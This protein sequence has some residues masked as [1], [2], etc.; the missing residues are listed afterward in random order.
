MLQIS[1]GLEQVDN[2]LGLVFAFDQNMPRVHL[3]LAAHRFYRI[4]VGLVHGFIGNCGLHLLL[5]L[6][7][8]QQ[9]VAQEGQA[10]L[11]FG[12]VRQLFLIGGLG[13]KDDVC[14]IRDQVVSFGLGRGRLQLGT[15]VFFREREITLLD[16]GPIHP[17]HD[18]IGSR[19]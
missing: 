11:E 9:L 1:A 15:E 4:I 5:Q 10:T 7:T 13:D 12:I 17:G 19:G 6:V 3:I 2:R 18:P 8:H 14:Q 16:L